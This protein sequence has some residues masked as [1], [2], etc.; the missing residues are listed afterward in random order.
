[1]RENEHKRDV[2]TPEENEYTRSRKKDSLMEVHPSGIMDHAVKANHTIDC[3]GVKFP[4]IDTDWTARVVRKSVKIRK[5][6]A[7]SM[8]RDGDTTN[9]DSCT[10]SC[11]GRNCC[12]MYLP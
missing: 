7:H 11:W 1:M 4:I 2:K 5:T 3:E 8:N 12:Y 9:Y 6:G 10:Q